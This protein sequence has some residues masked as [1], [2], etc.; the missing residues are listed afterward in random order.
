MIL[1][2][3]YGTGLT[4]C[5][6]FLFLALLTFF[7]LLN[8]CNIDNKILDFIIDTTPTKQNKFTPGTHIPVFPPEKIKNKGKNDVAL[9]LAWNYEAQILDKEKQFGI[10]GGKFLL[11]VPTP[12]LI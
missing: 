8:Y 2:E 3:Y 9:L 4:S 1:V 10:D 7:N 5:G 12:K 11:P 6:P